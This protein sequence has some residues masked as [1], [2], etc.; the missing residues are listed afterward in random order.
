MD[1]IAS[2]AGLICASAIFFYFVQLD[3]QKEVVAELPR[4]TSRTR[5][6]SAGGAWATVSTGSAGGSSGAG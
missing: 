3:K 4:R 2:V 1:P 5:S 6:P